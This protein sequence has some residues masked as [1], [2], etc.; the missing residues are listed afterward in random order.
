MARLIL[1]GALLATLSACSSRIEDLKSPCVGA[2]NSPCARRPVNE[3]WTPP[4][5]S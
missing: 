3:I 2:E 4:A 1:I 5:Q